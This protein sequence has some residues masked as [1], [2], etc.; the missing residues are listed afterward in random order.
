MLK[1]T[2]TNAV[3]V[4]EYTFD[5][6]AHPHARWGKAYRR[7]D[8]RIWLEFVGWGFLHEVRGERKAA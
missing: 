4:N 1:P 7:D 6:P 2:D 8:R 3:E 5:N